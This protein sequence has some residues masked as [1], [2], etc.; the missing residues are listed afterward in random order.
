M[1]PGFNEIIGK[2][3]NEPINREE[4]LFLFHEC[5]D[6]EKASLLYDA[7]Y[8]VREQEIGNV[9]HWYTRI[10]RKANCDLSPRCLYCN[11][12]DT[13]NE[14]RFISREELLINLSLARQNGIRQ[15]YLTEGAIN[16]SSE[17]LQA[18]NWTRDFGGDDIYF[19]IKVGA[20]IP[21]EMLPTLKELG[22]QRIDCGFET[23]NPAV[24][25][26]FRP[27]DNLEAKKRLVTEV[28]KAG[29]KLGTGLLAG[30]GPKETR[31]QDYVDFL[32][33]VTQ[34]DNLESLHVSR[35]FPYE[36]IPTADYPKC[37][38]REAACVIAIARLILRHV[39]ISGV[40]GWQ[41]DDPAPLM[42]GAGNQVMAYSAL[43]KP[44]PNSLPGTPQFGEA[45]SERR[46]FYRKLGL[47]IEP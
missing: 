3:L 45:M 1:K 14:L 10:G 41:C 12:R 38:L 19:N 22:I 11:H 47:D 40:Y 17:I 24:F 21:F 25:H 46:E 26:S 31:Y 20:A 44:N 36:G 4:A 23:I 18:V 29:L 32:F 30:L 35:F 42:A 8:K 7:A 37:S 39:A 9:F 16:D 28:G 43:D 6:K 15:V 2:S 13:G 5:E 33:Y 27:G 34:F